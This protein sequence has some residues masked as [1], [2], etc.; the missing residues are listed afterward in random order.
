MAMRNKFVNKIVHYRDK[1]ME[2]EIEI[3]SHVW[4][5]IEIDG[6]NCY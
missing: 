5:Y 2:K 4:L 3:N 6:I 1:W